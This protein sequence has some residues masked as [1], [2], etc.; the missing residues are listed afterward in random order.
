MSL[1]GIISCLI[2]LNLF[3]RHHWAVSIDSTRQVKMYMDAR[4]VGFGEI[5]TDFVEPTTM[6]QA[7]C[8]Y[9][10][11]G[12]NLVDCMVGGLD[13]LRIWKASLSQSLILR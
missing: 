4:L 6:I 3:A 8:E 2:V 9:D 12:E 10:I 13:E 11:D 7:L 5:S 1:Y